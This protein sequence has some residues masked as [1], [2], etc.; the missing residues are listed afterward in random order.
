MALIRL[1]DGVGFRK[2][3]VRAMRMKR[4][5]KFGTGAQP[6]LWA[7][8]VEATLFADYR[9]GIAVRTFVRVPIE[10]PTKLF[11]A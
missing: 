2:P 8:V 1:D 11:A 4:A 3:G 6:D 5:S 9:S 7:R 10:N